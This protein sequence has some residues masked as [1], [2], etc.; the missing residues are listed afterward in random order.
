[1]VNQ[2]TSHTIVHKFQVTLTRCDDRSRDWR[3]KA[4]CRGLSGCTVHADSKA[5]DL[6]RI[7]RAIDVWLDLAD[8]EVGPEG[9]EVEDFV[10]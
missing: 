4:C 1:M 2:Q 10:D 6:R 8:R 7:R 9:P 5:E 3:Y